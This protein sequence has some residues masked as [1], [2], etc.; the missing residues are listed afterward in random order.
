M[1]FSSNQLPSLLITTVLFTTHDGGYPSAYPLRFVACFYPEI[2]QI[3]QA[4]R[5]YVDSRIAEF[6]EILRKAFADSYPE[7]IRRLMGYQSHRPTLGT[8]GSV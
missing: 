8:W 3:V 2:V 5:I 4:R 6:V 7:H 1:W